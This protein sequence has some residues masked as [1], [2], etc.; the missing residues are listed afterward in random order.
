MYGDDDLITLIHNAIPH[1]F[2]NVKLTIGNK[3][4]EN[5]N[6]VGHVSSMMYGVLYARSKA[7]CDGLQFMWFPD[8]GK[9]AVTAE[10]VGFDIRKKYVI[11]QPET[12]GKFKLRIP[13]YMFYGFMKNFLVLKGYS[14]EIEMVRGPDYPALFRDATAAEGKLKFKSI[15][16]D[17]PIVEASTAVALEYIKQPFLYSFR[18]RHGMFAPV[19]PGL[20]DFQQPI[21]LN[22]F[23]ER[24]QMIWVG[25]QTSNVVNQ[26]ANRALYINA[27]VESM[28]IQMNS[29]QFPK[30]LM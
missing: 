14:M 4:V 27:D 24:T 21:T 25:F 8:S 23:T 16:L 12:N 18:Q 19:P 20:T 10:N 1:M 11:V 2:S 26:T 28:Y 17:V 7:K 15:T 22:Y 30:V 5:V 6:Q 3:L 29:S 13:M 9:T